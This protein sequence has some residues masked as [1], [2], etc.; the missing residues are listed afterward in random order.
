MIIFKK[1]RYKNFL[2]TGN[3]FNEIILNKTKSTLIMGRNGAGKTTF[4]QA[5]VFALYGKAYA[6]INKNQ[7]V[8]SITRKDCLVEL[9]FSIGSTNYFVRRG[10]KPNIFEI[11]QNDVLIDQDSNIG[12]YQELLE[13]I[14]KM[15]YKSCCQHV[16]L[17]STN[18][19]PFMELSAGDRRTVVED[20]LDIQIF[21]VMNSILKQKNDAIK[22]E[23]EAI[24]NKIELSEKLIEAN[25]KHAKNLKTNNDE[26]INLKKSQIDEIK[27]SIATSYAEIQALEETEERLRS[28][29]TDNGSLSDK[30]ISLLDFNR[31]IK[32]KK[33]STLKDIKFFEE[34]N[35][36]PTCKQSID[37]HFKSNSIESKNNLIVNYDEALSKIEVQY[38][39][40][41]TRLNEI[42]KIYENITS[43]SNKIRDLKSTIKNSL[44]IIDR[45]K[46]EIKTI[47]QNSTKEDTEVDNK[48]LIEQLE[49]SIEEKNK[50]FERKKMQEV[51]GILLKDSGIKTKIINKYVPLINKYINKYLSELDFFVNFEIDDKF[52][53]TIKSR[54]RDDF[55]YSSFSEGEKARIN[56]ALMFAWRE[57]AKLRNSSSCNLLIMDEVTDSS[58]D[59][60]GTEYFLKIIDSLSHDNN[61]FVISHHGDRLYDKFHSVIEVNKVKNFSKISR[62]VNYE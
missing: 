21:S 4:I 20:L 52:N 29:I 24:S 8:N 9:E 40:V 48:K 28:S 38:R 44:S 46:N 41:E 27:N 15:N 1:L 3:E 57:I 5:F 58:L 42:S 37:E 54:G 39:A 19:I 32:D 51:A 7:L 43:V 34:N 16:I 26:I 55:T 25:N 36:C 17:G 31:K 23:I 45:Y 2:S 22:S 18:Y 6:K 35:E 13:N 11:Y 50:L 10:I 62:K 14:I 33:N 47:I 30:K 56:L 59:D 12:D 49:S 53:E 61:I 60:E